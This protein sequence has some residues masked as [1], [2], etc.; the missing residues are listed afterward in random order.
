MTKAEK[1][2]RFAHRDQVDK[3]NRP[4]IHHLER[5]VNAVVEGAENVAWLHDYFED[6]AT[7]MGEINN[8]RDFLTLEECEALYLLT[9][10]DGISY[11]DY[12]QSIKDCDNRLARSVK[13]IDIWDHLLDAEEAGIGQSLIDRYNLAWT[14]LTTR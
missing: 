10:Q 8:F 3:Q 7:D 6:I 14:V 1:I 13:L 12:I 11:A 9:R 2:A 4:Y 5:V